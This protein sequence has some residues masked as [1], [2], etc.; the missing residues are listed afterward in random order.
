[1]SLSSNELVALSFD[2]ATGVLQEHPEAVSEEFPLQITCM[3]VA[4]LL[5]GRKTSRWLVAGTGEDQA[6]RVLD[7]ETGMEVAA[8]QALTGAPTDLALVRDTL[9]TLILHVAVEGGIWIR[10]QLDESSGSL[11]HPTSR[12]IGPC[13]EP[14]FCSLASGNSMFALGAR[15]WLETH[16]KL[17]RPV[18]AP[19]F[20][21]RIVAACAFDGVAFAAI[22]GEGS[23]RILKIVPGSNSS[24][25]YRQRLELPAESGSIKKFAV[26]Q[27]TGLIAIFSSGGVSFADVQGSRVGLGVQY[28]ENESALTGCFVRF[29]DRLNETFLAVAGARNFITCPRQARGG[30]FIDLFPIDPQTGVLGARLH[31]TELE[32]TGA[33][34]VMVAFNGRL[35]VGVDLDLRLY[36][37]GRVRLLRKT[38]TRL[39][40]VAVTIRSQGLRLWIGTAKH[41]H[42]LLVYRPDTNSFFAVA[43]DP[44]PRAVTADCVLDYESIAGADRFGNVFVDRLSVAASEALDSER[45]FASLN[46][47]NEKLERLSEFFVN[48]TI[49]ALQRV[50][51]AGEAGRKAIWYVSVSGAVGCLVPL[52]TRSA[53]AAAVDLQSTLRSLSFDSD[54]LNREAA[55]LTDLLHRSHLSQQS[56]FVPAKGVVDGD[57]LEQFLRLPV[58][59]QHSIVARLDK[60]LSEVKKQI[61]EYRRLIGL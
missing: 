47:S 36:D 56:N 9:G 21:S 22:D 26:H 59:L 18:N 2:P 11:Q 60:S 42:N 37:L 44:L 46:G 7:S 3:A 4:P 45:L 1:M 20:F 51:W 34:T 55:P 16:D 58:P 41:S 24:P 38:Q 8:I 30:S 50:S 53:A 33:P 10:F 49:V 27:E 25:F 19:L 23:L 29:H 39:P 31:R 61:E 40:S 35:L 28:H 48:D 17:G 32:A 13:D 52:P 57:F 14:R 5:E 54:A 43:D 12:F 15:P 6:I